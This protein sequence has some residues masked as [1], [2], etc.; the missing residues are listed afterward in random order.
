M[1]NEVIAEKSDKSIRDG[2]ARLFGAPHTDESLCSRLALPRAAELAGVIVESNALSTGELLSISDLSL[3]PKVKELGFS[4]VAES[5]AL[6]REAKGDWKQLQI[7][8]F[9]I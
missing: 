8:S 2:L 9:F 7:L 4:A 5:D 1:F 6:F 3:K